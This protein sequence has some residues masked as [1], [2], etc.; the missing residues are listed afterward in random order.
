MLGSSWRVARGSFRD[1][2]FCHP[3][4]THNAFKRPVIFDLSFHSSSLL[5]FGLDNLLSFFVFSW[6]FDVSSLGFCKGFV[7]RAVF[8]QLGGQDI[9]QKSP[10]TTR[11]PISSI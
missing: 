6:L 10:E 9:Q 11:K 7:F 1:L 3:Q 2:V 8:A 5:Q 4:M